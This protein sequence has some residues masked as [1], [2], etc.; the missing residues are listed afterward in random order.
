[1]SREI[2]TG[3]SHPQA[4]GEAQS[5]SDSEIRYGEI[6][7]IECHYMNPYMTIEI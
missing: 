3:E 4:H 5:D 6:S 2:S 1:M 7:N